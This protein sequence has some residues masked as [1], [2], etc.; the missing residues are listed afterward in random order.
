[1]TTNCRRGGESSEGSS[2]DEGEEFELDSEQEEEDEGEIRQKLG[3]VEIG[4][5]VTGGQDDR[6]QGR[7]NSNYHNNNNN[8]NIANDEHVSGIAPVGEVRGT[9]GTVRRRTR[10]CLLPAPFFWCCMHRFVREG[11]SN[12]SW[13]GLACFDGFLVVFISTA[14]AYDHNCW[15]SFT[16]LTDTSHEEI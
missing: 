16:Q 13:R 15:N 10:S 2:Q 4:H 11:S 8:N 6:Q 7:V 3:Q 9:V 12:S 1:M 5:Y 14:I